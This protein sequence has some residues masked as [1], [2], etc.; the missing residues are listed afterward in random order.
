M[1][2][3]WLKCQI[4]SSL[5]RDDGF[6]THDEVMIWKRFPHYR[7]FV[8]WIHRWPVNSLTKGQLCGAL[9]FLYCWPEQA[10]EEIIELSKIAWLSCE[11]T[12]M[13]DVTGVDKA[14]CFRIFCFDKNLL[15]NVQIWKGKVVT[16]TIS[17]ILEGLK[18]VR[19]TV[20]QLQRR[21]ISQRDNIFV[22][23]WW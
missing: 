17:S 19:V 23:K 5:P 8:R 15:Q 3:V 14:V 10:I 11:V 13:E 18:T 2:S 21:S 9:W 22:W 20:S 7:R 16:L 12:G 4:F 1:F 6:I